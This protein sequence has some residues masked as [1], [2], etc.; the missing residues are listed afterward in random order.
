VNSW[1]QSVWDLKKTVNMRRARNSPTNTRKT[2][3]R[4]QNRRRHLLRKCNTASFDEDYNDQ[5]EIA[6]GQTLR[7][8]CERKKRKK[9]KADAR[10]LTEQG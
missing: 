8:I 6:E 7:E 2:T 9:E 5:G 1:H 10:P 3:R 4:P